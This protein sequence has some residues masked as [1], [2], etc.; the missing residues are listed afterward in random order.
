LD[1]LILSYDD[2]DY[3]YEW[4]CCFRWCCTDGCYQIL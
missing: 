3:E 2:Y 1:L 4:L